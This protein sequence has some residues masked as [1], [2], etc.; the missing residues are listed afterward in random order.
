MKM[1]RRPKLGATGKYPHGK[2]EPTDEGEL[3]LAVFI[4]KGQVRIE[5]GKPIA[6]LAL[7]PGQAI[8]F[9]DL[10]KEHAAKIKYTEL[11]KK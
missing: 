8:E 7:P 9:A 6:W 11:E 4:F 2:L 10:I 1:K 5:F 3:N